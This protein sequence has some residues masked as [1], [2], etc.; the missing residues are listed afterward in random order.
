[1]KSEKITFTVTCTM[2]ERWIS[3]FLAML[4]YMESLGKLGGTRTISFV[5]DGDGDF[6]PHFQWDEKLPANAHPAY[7]DQM[8]NRTYDAG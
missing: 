6:R 5:S 3:P 8:G 1:M 2:K 7:E 4:K